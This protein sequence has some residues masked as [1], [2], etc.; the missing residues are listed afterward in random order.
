M[1]KEPTPVERVIEVDVLGESNTRPSQLARQ[2][3]KA[4]LSLRA[5]N[6]VINFSFDTVNT[7]LDTILARTEI[8]DEWTSR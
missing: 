6:D 4:D 7:E 3:A 1:L 8:L 5:I 2:W